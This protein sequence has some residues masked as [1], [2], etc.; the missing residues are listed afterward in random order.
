METHVA[1]VNA[2]NGVWLC[3]SEVHQNFRLL[4]D[5]GSGQSLLGANFVECDNHGGIISALDVEERAGYALHGRDA[6]FYK[7]WCGCGVRRV[8]H[9]AP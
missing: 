9:L 6:A 4:D 2:D 7:F 8:L 1:S 5:I 3:G